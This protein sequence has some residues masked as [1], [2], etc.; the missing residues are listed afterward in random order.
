MIRDLALIS[1]KN[2]RES[3]KGEFECSKHDVIIY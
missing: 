3:E 2:D 1:W